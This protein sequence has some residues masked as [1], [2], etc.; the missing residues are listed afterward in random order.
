MAEYITQ[1]S[2]ANLIQDM[3]YTIQQG[4][5]R[6][7][8]ARRRPDIYGEDRFH[9]GI[10]YTGN[11]GS[12]QSLT[13][14]TVEFA[15]WLDNVYGYVVRVKNGDFAFTYCH[16]DRISD[17]IKQNVH[18]EQGTALGVIGDTGVVTG[19]H[20]HLIT[21]L[22]GQQVNP[23]ETLL[24]PPSM[25]G[26]TTFTY[27]D[28]ITEAY[29]GILGREPDTE[30]LDMYTA[31]VANEEMTIADVMDDFVQSPEFRKKRLNVNVN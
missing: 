13:S 17:V 16:L 18:V 22:N 23:E 29:R 9:H 6:T 31:R 28:I 20:V 10:D 4:Y 5:G 3:G 12:C 26:D 2:V 19:P 1:K 11:G 30:G 24:T 25:L 7:P 15:N 8:F 21:E 14:G 27:K